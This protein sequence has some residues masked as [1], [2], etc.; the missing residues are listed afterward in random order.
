MGAVG[1]DLHDRG[2][3][4]NRGVVVAG[5]GTDCK[6]AACNESDGRFDGI[7]GDEWFIA[8]MFT[9]TSCAR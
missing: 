4:E 9:M 8:L 7:L 2:F 6:I 3:V 1:D 5:C